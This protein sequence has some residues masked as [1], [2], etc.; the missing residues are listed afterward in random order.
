[1]DN[2][3]KIAET[4]IA[5]MQ[6][7]FVYTPWWD[8]PSYKGGGGKVLA[9]LG[10]LE[11]RR[12]VVADSISMMAQNDIPLRD[13]P[14]VNP[15]ATGPKDYANSCR[16]CAELRLEGV[17]EGT[18]KVGLDVFLGSRTARALLFVLVDGLM[19]FGMQNQHH[20]YP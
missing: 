16:N 1:M 20:R 2:F 12:N 6:R 5:K 15:L 13:G 9:I 3:V 10:D 18:A 11:G 14:L 8:R 19:D 4:Q 7:K 17:P